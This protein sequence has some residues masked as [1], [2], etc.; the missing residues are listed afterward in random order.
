MITK[1]FRVIITCEVLSLSFSTAPPA[2][3]EIFIGID[4]QPFN[5]SNFAATKTPDCSQ[6]VTYSLS[7]THAFISIPAGTTNVQVNG[8]NI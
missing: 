7:T 3:T 6:P 1:T 8:V 2:T 5:V 4:T